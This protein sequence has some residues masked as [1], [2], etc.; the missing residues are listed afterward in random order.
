M[1]GEV[2]RKTRAPKELNGSQIVA[3]AATKVKNIKETD[4]AVAFKKKDLVRMEKIKTSSVSM[5]PM[6]QLV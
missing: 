6:N 5:L 2:K 1:V 3:A 4:G